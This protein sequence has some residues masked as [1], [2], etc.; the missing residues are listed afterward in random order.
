MAKTSP[1]RLEKRDRFVALYHS[2][3]EEPMRQEDILRIARQ[4]QEMDDF[5]NPVFGY[6][7]ANVF[8]KAGDEESRVACLENLCDRDYPP[9]QHL[10]GVIRVN[11]G[12]TERGYAL[13]E[14]AVDAG[15]YRAGAALA[16]YRRR[17]TFNPFLKLWYFVLRNYYVVRSIYSG[18]LHYEKDGSPRIKYP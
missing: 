14:D 3:V 10:L 16:I 1:E 5:G 18:Q 4:M 7:V 13:L 2:V 11:E 15:Y 17:S 12:A 9:A 6:M 8:G